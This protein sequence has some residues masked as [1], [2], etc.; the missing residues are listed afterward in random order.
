MNRGQELTCKVLILGESKVGKSSILN[1]FTEGSYSENLPPTLGIDYKIVRHKVAGMEGKLQIW[2]TAGQE[3]FRSITESFYK[4]CNAVLLVFDL[5]DRE[6]FVKV[7]TWLSNIHEKAGMG[8]LI[9]LLGNKC[10]LRTKPGVEMIPQPEID[11]LVQETQIQYF[12][13]SA[14]EDVNVTEAFG[15]AAR[16]VAEREREAK[17][18]SLT[19]LRINAKAPEPKDKCCK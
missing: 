19:D 11:A 15:Y 14:K 7:K 5:S 1:R 10:D 9:V 3:R 13:T 17:V 2:D 12:S 16:M 18:S 6:S 8:V 4:G